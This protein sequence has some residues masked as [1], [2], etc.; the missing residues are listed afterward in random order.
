MKGK[1]SALCLGFIIIVSGCSSAVSRADVPANV[2]NFLGEKIL[3][4]IID[5]DSCMP[6]MVKPEKTKDTKV[7]CLHGF[8]VTKE[9]PALPVDELNKLKRIL[10]DEKTY[11]FKY[12]KRAFVFP[13]YAFVFSK[14]NEEV[15]VFFDFYRK[16]VLLVNEGKELVEDFDNA[17]NDVRA[18]I[19]RIF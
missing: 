19:D 15:I 18:V 5:A 9:G 11:D 10:L 17:E 16:E 6:F 14:G 13:E 4:I 1:L 7:K 3:A 2:K 8:P 12:A